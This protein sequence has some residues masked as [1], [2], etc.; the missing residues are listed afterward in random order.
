ML[1]LDGSGGSPLIVWTLWAGNFTHHLTRLV[2]SSDDAEI[3]DIARCYDVE[4]VI[5]PAAMA[6][7][8]A[9]PYPAMLHALDAQEMPYD[10]LCL[11]QPT[12]PFRNGLDVDTAI[13]LALND[14]LPAVV[15][16]VSHIYD[17]GIVNALANS[18]VRD[19]VRVRRDQ[20]VVGI[21][22]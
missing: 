20:V 18:S 17:S 1:V 7:D 13:A 12:S 16:V 19:I 11:L 4:T 9:S 8:E 14:D 21:K 15:F 22:W 5:R 6:T 3:L 10:Y 2:V